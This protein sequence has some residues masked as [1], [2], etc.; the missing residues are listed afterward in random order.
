VD[1]N[2]NILKNLLLS[3]L[4][5]IGFFCFISYSSTHAKKA[6][7]TV[8]SSKT[9]PAST[10]ILPGEKTFLKSVKLLGPSVSNFLASQDNRTSIHNESIKIVP[11]F[12]FI[13]QFL[14]QDSYNK[15]FASGLHDPSMV[16]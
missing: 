13:R 11:D 16:G 9:L 4:L 14:D 2:Q 12:L 7:L 5:L 1:K 6:D 10:N 8:T 15:F 3:A